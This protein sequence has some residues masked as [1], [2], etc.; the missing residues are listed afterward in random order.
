M[1]NEHPSRI[2]THRVAATEARWTSFDPILELG[3]VGIESDTGKIKVGDGSTRWASLPYLTPGGGGVTDHGGLTGLADDDHTQYHNDTRGDARYSLLAHT[4]AGVYSPVGHTHVAANITDFDSAA[5]AATASAYATAGHN[6]S[7]V[8]QPVDGDLTAIAALSGTGG[9]AKRTA[10]DTWTISTP[11]AADVG[12]AAASHSHAISDVTSLQ[13]TLDG[14]KPYLGVG[15]RG[16]LTLSYD[17]ATRK[18]TITGAAEIWKLGVKETKANPY[19]FGAHANATSGYFFY[20]DENGTEVVDANPWDLTTDIPIC[21]VFY[22][23]TLVE[24]IAFY[25]LHSALR[26][27][28]LHKRLHFCDGTRAEPGSGFL[29][30]GYVLNSDLNADKTLAISGGTIWDEDIEYDVTGVADGGPYY[31][32]H[33]TGASGVWTWTKTSSYPFRDDGTNLQYNEFTGATWQLTALTAGTPEFMNVWVFATS[34][35]AAGFQIFFLVGQNKYSSQSAAEAESITGISW[36]TI[37]FQEI[38]PLYQLTYRRSAANSNAGKADLRRVAFIVGSRSTI[39]SATVSP[40]TAAA[41][42]FVPAGA[43]ASTN[44]QAAIE[45]LDTEKLALAGGTMTGAIVIPA[46]AVGTPAVQVTG[47]LTTGIYSSGTDVLDVAIAGTNRL[48]VAAGALSVNTNITLASTDRRILADWNNATLASR[49]FF[50]SASGNNPTYVGAIPVNTGTASGFEAFNNSTPTDAGFAAMRCDASNAY[51]IAS[52][53]GT[54]TSL[55]LLIQT[56]NTPTTAITIGTDQS[57]QLAATPTVGGVAV[58]LSNHTHGQLH[59]R[60][61]AMTGTSDHTAGNWKAFYSDGSGQVQEVALGASGTV[62]KSNGAA[63]APTFASVP[64]GEAFPV[65]AVYINVTGVNPATELGYGTWSAFGAG[66]VLVGYDSGDTDFDTAEETG[67]AKT[68]SISAHSGTAVADHAA[69]THSVTSNVTVDNHA[70]H[71]HEYSEVVTH[72]HSVNVGSNNDTSYVTGSG[73]YFA[74]TNNTVTAT[75]AAPGTAVSTG[76]T[77]VQKQNSGAVP[78]STLTMSHTVT[79]NAVTSGNPSATLTHSVTQPGDHTALNVVQPYIVVHF[80]K[81][82]A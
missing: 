42:S 34:S 4:H 32:F 71:V 1:I 10:A 39:S 61:H 76:T 30:S 33:R 55:P 65:G 47:S 16:S 77:T 41:V 58:S 18:V 50:R 49:A 3:V 40:T 24:G 5:L 22:D 25:E 63:A 56:G 74:G 57:I 20:F 48:S 70:D 9:W 78:R 7:G 60:S 31:V 2:E 36:G 68:K 21:Y 66:K 26:D 62:L 6:H 73:N 12:A 54:G 82:T 8:Y 13:T 79:N 59:D 17:S 52:R 51:L 14:K 64:A 80:W 37:P 44:V 19:V 53:S 45:E 67:G 81:R 72:T 29:A 38:V 27:P 43:I 75:A 69:H 35:L 23:A 46:G 28:D 15:N 11:T